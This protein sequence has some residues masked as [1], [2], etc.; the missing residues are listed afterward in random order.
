MWLNVVSIAGYFGEQYTL[1]ISMDN[2]RLILAHKEI[3][4][5]V[6]GC[7]RGY[8]VS[9]PDLNYTCSVCD[10]ATY[11]IME[12]FVRQCHSCDPEDNPGEV[13][14]FCVSETSFPHL[15]WLSM[16]LSRFFA[17]VL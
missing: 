9:A 6:T 8:G 16:S 15:I 17:S 2:N 14:V 4:F 7:P 11:N 10:A 13:H 1:Q 3:T 5:N 12:D